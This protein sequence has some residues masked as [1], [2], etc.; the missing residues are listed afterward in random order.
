MSDRR[1]STQRGLAAASDALLDSAAESVYVVGGLAAV[2]DAKLHGRSIYRVAGADRW[3]TARAAGAI[4]EQIAQGITLAFATVDAPPAQPPATGFT[5][6]TGWCGL[7]VDG[8]PACWRYDF[9]SEAVVSFDPPVS[10]TFTAISS[11]IGIYRCGL[12]VDGSAA[13]WRYDFDS[14]AVVGFDPPV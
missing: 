6:V 12:R 13:C 8:S 3:A 1:R 14:E 7:R 9:D 11:R 2:P 4:A 10:G 5:A